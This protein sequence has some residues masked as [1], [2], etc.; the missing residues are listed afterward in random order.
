MSSIKPPTGVA[1]GPGG[2]D[3]LHEGAEASELER[4]P[5]VPQ[6]VPGTGGAARPVGA[7]QAGAPVSPDAVADI[8]RAVAAGTLP[9]DAALEQLVE[10]AVGPMVSKL[11]EAERDELVALLRDAL[12]HDPAL[13]AL[14]ESLR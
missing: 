4:A 11:S 8:A 5:G 1:A 3:A 6:D 14:R 10:R 13:G 7:G 12:A 9:L 2:P